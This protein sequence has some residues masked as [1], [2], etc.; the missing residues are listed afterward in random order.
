MARSEL[1]FL[2]PWTCLT[3][4]AVAPALGLHGQGIVADANRG[5]GLCDLDREADK[6]QLAVRGRDVGRELHRPARH[7]VYSAVDVGIGRNLELVHGRAHGRQRGRVI[8]GDLGKVGAAQVDLGP[9]AVIAQPVGDGGQPERFAG[10]TKEA[11]AWFGA[12]RGESEL[13]VKPE[14]AYTV[15]SIL[16]AIYNSAASGDVVRMG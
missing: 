7:D 12:V 13:V 8:A 9:P 5:T 10:G 11:L 1:K 15:T 2:L 4:R 3:P 16:E 6:A 14:Q